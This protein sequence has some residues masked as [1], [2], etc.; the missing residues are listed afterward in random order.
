MI[1]AFFQAL[2]RY[3][4]LGLN[5]I[6]RD[7]SNRY[8]GAATGFFLALLQPLLQLAVFA[9]VFGVVFPSAANSGHSFVLFLA[10]GLWPWLMFREGL[11]RASN[12]LVSQAA[13]IGKVAFPRALLIIATV[14]GSFL[15]HLMGFALVLLVLALFDQ[16]IYLAGLPLALFYLLLLWLLAMA[17]GL[18]ASTLTV[19]WREW[20]VVQEAL[21]LA[22]FY[23]TPIL[24]RLDTVPVLWRDY[25]SLNPLANVFARLRDALLKGHSDWAM[26]ELVA[27]LCVS[28]LLLLSIWWFSRLEPH[29][30]DA[31]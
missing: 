29:I 26:S 21:L 13:L 14:T 11:G 17:L 3:R 31:L 12:S 9:L 30:D 25:L 18:F 27:L 5:L 23:L 10:L 16:T 6:E 19:Y 1:R 7:L 20:E 28:T 22:L 4:Y 24:Y 8:A 2:W 15:L